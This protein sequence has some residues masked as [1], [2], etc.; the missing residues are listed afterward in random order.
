MNRPVLT[1]QF[2]NAEGEV[3]QAPEGLV[4]HVTGLFQLCLD[5]IGE[6]VKIATIGIVEED[7]AGLDS[8]GE[9]VV[10]RAKVISYFDHNINGTILNMAA[11]SASFKAI[12]ITMTLVKL[13]FPGVDGVDDEVGDTSSEFLAQ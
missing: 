6:F 11:A 13:A 4:R 12:A 10:V 9:V 5:S 2:T 8:V 7:L 1:T 3:I